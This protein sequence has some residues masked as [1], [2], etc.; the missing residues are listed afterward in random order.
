MLIVAE[1]GD[2]NPDEHTPGYLSVFRFVPQQT[3]EFEREVSELHR[4]H[5]SE[6]CSLYILKCGSRNAGPFP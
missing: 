5:R 6:F 1:M 4:Q 3:E 2:F